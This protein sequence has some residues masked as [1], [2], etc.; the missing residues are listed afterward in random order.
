VQGTEGV[1][2][3]VPRIPSQARPDV[4]TARL[5]GIL[6]ICAIGVAIFGGALTFL[7]AVTFRSIVPLCGLGP[8]VVLRALIMAMMGIVLRISTRRA[9]GWT[10]IVGAA[11]ALTLPALVLE[12]VLCFCL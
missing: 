12:T 10:I 2:S 11:G 1:R 9:G 5:A 4:R 8:I 7:L 6:G 3:A